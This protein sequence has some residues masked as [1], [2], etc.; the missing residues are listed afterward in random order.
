MIRFGTAKET[1]ARLPDE[2]DGVRYNFFGAHPEDATTGQ[3]HSK[4]TNFCQRWRLDCN[5]EIWAV[6]D[7]DIRHIGD[8]GYGGSLWELVQAIKRQKESTGQV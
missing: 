8:F 4:D 7:A 5:G 3:H 2:Y 6:L 1:T